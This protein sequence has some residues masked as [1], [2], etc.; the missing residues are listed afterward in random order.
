MTVTVATDGAAPV[1]VYRGSAA[2]SADAK[3][4][5]QLLA[6]LDLGHWSGK[7]VLVDISG[8]VHRRFMGSSSIGYAAC[9]AKLVTSEGELPFDFV[10]WQQ[11]GELGLHIRQLGP[12]VWRTGRSGR[13][14]FA[15]KGTLWR[16]L[17]VPPSG[18]LKL[19]IGPLLNAEVEARPR[20]AAVTKEPPSPPSAGGQPP[21]EPRPDVFIYLIDACRPD[22]LGCYGYDR[23]TSPN[24][25]RF[26]REATLYQNANAASTWTR[27]SVATILTGLYA[28]VHGA[29]HE[30]DAL[31][32]W[33]EL[34]PE[35]LRSAGYRTCCITANGNVTGELGFNQGY[36]EFS[37]IN[38]APA[39]MIDRMVARRLAAQPAAEPV[40]MYLH[41]V[42]TH[43]PWN[44]SAD[45]F[46]RFDRGF[47]GR[48]KGSTA[49]L[50][51]ISVLR[52]DLTRDDLGQL[53][54]L[55]DARVYEADQGYGQ[56]V[57]TLKRAGRYD[58]ALI[59]LVSDHGEAFGEHDTF[60]HGWA[61]NRETMHVL[62]AVKYP[63][64]RE[65]GVV[66]TRPVSLID[67]VPTVLRETGAAPPSYRLPGRSLSPRG[68]EPDRRLYA[69][70]SEWAAN[71]LDLVAAID[72]DGYKRVIDTSVLP[73]ETAPKKSIGLWDTGSDPDERTDLTGKLPV[74]AAYDEQLLA[75]WLLDQ[76]GSRR[77]A[78]GSTP[79]P[80]VKMS[81]ELKRKLQN[82][83][84]LKGG[85]H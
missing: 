73:R 2:F 82:L 85:R 79:S 24:I 47:K 23:P 58:N 42:E 72:E 69:E 12:V 49:S 9:E 55:Y 64:C 11:G 34:L 54:D 22:H 81:E 26:A 3:S 4:R 16:A 65:A 25:D 45:A 57:D 15:Q 59:I 71:N 75:G 41:T 62:L 20:P 31:A 78:G 67:I 19:R 68:L 8:A 10:S 39:A 7:L 70:V 48:Y 60:G 32:Q 28:C 38:E 18:R 84:Y 44:P 40:F 17:R 46:R 74:R 29:M 50:D 27:P 33:P 21:A 43:G 35:L 76:L 1:I 5:P 36:D 61:L 66:A 51:K 63:H 52:P 6:D 56:F 83:G 37:F 77:R 53:V 14:V 30:T 80:R 13:A